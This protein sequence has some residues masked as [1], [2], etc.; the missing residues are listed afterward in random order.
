MISNKN[1]AGRKPKPHLKIAVDCGSLSQER[2]KRKGGI[3]TLAYNFLEQLAIID[4]RNTYIFYS[5]AAIP[6]GLLKRFGKR[7]VNKVLT[8][9]LGYKSV[10]LPLA[11]KFDKPDVF[12]ALSQ[13]V[14]KNA[15][16]TI[17]FLYDIAFLEYPDL[18]INVEKLKQ[19]TEELAQKS[20]HILTISQASKVD[21]TKKYSFSEDKITVAYPGVSS[22]FKPKGPKFIGAVPYFLYVGHLKKTKNIPFL[23][24]AF[25][26]FQKKSSKKYE[27]MLVGSDED[28]DEDISRKIKKLQLEKLVKVRGHVPYKDLPKYYRGAA[29]FISIALYEGFGLPIVEAMAC[30]TPVIVGSNSSMP[31]IVEK[32]A[33]VVNEH[34]IK[35][36]VEGMMKMTEDS[37]SR[38]YAKKSIKQAKKYNWATFARKFYSIL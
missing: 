25:Y 13:A 33:I 7:A 16:R 38:D 37:L 5:F 11:L 20:D 2:I 6:K 28:L 3:Y 23:I 21:I 34:S 15:P 18:Y 26:Q 19:N 32:S 24:E 17:G 14:P 30:G 31:E 9:S 1:N 12:V 22:D 8:P 36:I 27:L 10:R 4:L 35:S 29:A